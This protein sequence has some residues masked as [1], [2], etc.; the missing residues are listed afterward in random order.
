MAWTFR[1]LR[2]GGSAAQPAIL[3][4]AGRAQPAILAEAGRAQPSKS[5]DLRSS[6]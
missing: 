6:F 5:I 3:A 2:H 4:E 1:S